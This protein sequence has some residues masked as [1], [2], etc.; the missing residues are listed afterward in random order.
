[1]QAEAG[2]EPLVIPE[3]LWPDVA[4]QQEARM[5][6]D[7]WEDELGARLGRLVARNPAMLVPE[8]SFA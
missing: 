7:P 3:R 8:G 2:E 4:V 6:L 1:M 5:E